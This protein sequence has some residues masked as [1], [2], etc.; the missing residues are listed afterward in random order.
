[1]I[2]QITIAD[3]AFYQET[4]RSFTSELQV[5]L[6]G[7]REGDLGSLAQALEHMGLQLERSSQLVNSIHQH[8]YHVDAQMDTLQKSFTE[9]EGRAATFGATQV[10]QADMQST[11]QDQMETG[12]RLALQL[13]NIITETSTKIESVTALAQTFGAVFDWAMIALIGIL[14]SLTVTF[15]AAIWRLSRTWFVCVLATITSF[16][17][18]H[19]LCYSTYV[20]AWL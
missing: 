1:M 3:G 19:M 14:G 16:T 4:S 6:R 2:V 13:R 11:L 5:S 17:A 12:V 20:P 8:Q 18:L 7:I 15:L 10:S 9:M